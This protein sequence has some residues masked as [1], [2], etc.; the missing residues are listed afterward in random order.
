MKYFCFRII[1]VS[2]YLLL[3]G[4]LG[5]AKTLTVI[6]LANASTQDV[7]QRFLKEYSRNYPG[8]DFSVSIVQYSALTA[9]INTLVTAG[10]P[11][12]ILEVNGLYP[13][14]SRSKPWIW[15]STRTGRIY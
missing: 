1:C 2:A 5:F 8:I 11:P 12:D 14:I 15:R 9:K 7:I 6:L 10:E 3:T 4:S 13:D